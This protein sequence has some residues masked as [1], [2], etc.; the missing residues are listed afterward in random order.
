MGVRF[1]TWLAKSSAE[2]VLQFREGDTVD[3]LDSALG[4]L[5]H[6]GTADRTV[7]IDAVLGSDLVVAGALGRLV[8][9][10]LIAGHGLGLRHR[11]ATAVDSRTQVLGDHVLAALLGGPR[12]DDPGRQVEHRGISC[13]NGGFGGSVVRTCRLWD[14]HGRTQED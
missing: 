1:T 8:A 9:D 6:D 10:H 4:V 2:I 12:E 7:I 14:S 3:D 5:L 11:W 13:I